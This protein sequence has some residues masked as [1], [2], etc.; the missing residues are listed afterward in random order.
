MTIRS[1]GSCSQLQQALSE[2]LNR[3]E[4]LNLGPK[5]AERV[6]EDW[7]VDNLGEFADW[8]DLPDLELVRRQ[9]RFADRTRADLLCRSTTR[10][11]AF[12]KGLWVVIELKAGLLLPIDV[13]QIAGYVAAVERELDHTGRGVLG[14]LVGDGWDPAVLARIE[15]RDVAVICQNLVSI[16]FHTALFEST[17]AIECDE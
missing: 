8:C 11:G 9:Y 17:R 12:P 1:S 5:A 7:I 10:K 14:V 13:D 3:Q 15:E 4:H 16:G 6:V 2:A